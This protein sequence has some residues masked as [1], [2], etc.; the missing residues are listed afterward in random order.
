MSKQT[1]AQKRRTT[2]AGI[3]LDREIIQKLDGLA[4]DVPRSRFVQRLI[5][6]ALRKKELEARK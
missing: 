4:G 3:S 2:N 5:E 1:F 6:R